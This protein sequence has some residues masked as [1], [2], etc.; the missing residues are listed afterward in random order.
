MRYARARGIMV[1]LES[2]GPPR[3]SGPERRRSM[4]FV[5][6]LSTRPGNTFQEGVAKRLQ[7]DYP[8]GANVLGEYWLETESPRVVA[9][10]EAE[11]GME[12]ARQ[13]MGGQG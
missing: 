13:V 7:W 2:E 1:A 12:M 5:A 3:V 4:L 10:V 9:I 8:E 6:L 11:Q